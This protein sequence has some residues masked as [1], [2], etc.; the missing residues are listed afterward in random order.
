MIVFPNAK[1]NLGLNIVAKRDD[2]YHNIETI[3]YPIGWSDILEIVPSESETTLTVTGRP[4]ICDIEKNLVMK[5]YRLM[6]DIYNI[7]NVTINLHKI[8]PDGAGLGGG[9]SDAAH[10]LIVLNTLFKLNLSQEILAKLAAKLGADCPFFIYNKPM[11]ASGIG[12]ELTPITI[13]LNSYY[14]LIVKPQVS[15]PTAV[16]YSNVIPSIPKYELCE[17]VKY[18]IELWSDKIKNDFEKNVFKTYPV[19]DKLKKQISKMGALY[20]S[21]SGSG[22]SVY[23]IFNRDILSENLLELFPNCDIY[24]NK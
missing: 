15:V 6:S 23:G 16:A 2:G 10:T 14:I 4:I 8:I 20:V 3:M 17:L 22:A 24:I 12:T 11:F 5:A 7:P 19:I 9:S 1:I 21:M 18:P 13:D